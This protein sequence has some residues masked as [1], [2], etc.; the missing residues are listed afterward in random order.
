MLNY[1]QALEWVQGQVEAGQ[2]RLTAKTFAKVQGMVV[3]GLWSKAGRSILMIDSQTGASRQALIDMANE[4]SPLRLLLN[5]RWAHYLRNAFKDPEFSLKDGVIRP[6]WQTMIIQNLPVMENLL[7]EHKHKTLSELGLD[8]W[9]EEQFQ[10][11]IVILAHVKRKNYR[12]CYEHFRLWGGGYTDMDG[13]YLK[14]QIPFDYLL[15]NDKANTIQKQGARRVAETMLRI[16]KT[17]DQ[18]FDKTVTAAQ[19]RCI[20]RQAQKG[21]EGGTEKP[22]TKPRPEMSGPMAEYM[23]LHRHSIARAALIKHPKM[24]T[25]SPICA[26]TRIGP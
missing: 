20:D 24:A 14:R 9:S 2:F 4:G 3:D 15:C 12:P 1:N 21:I 25:R 17:E 7:G 11:L 22:D 5:P 19:A 16:L 23:N 10:K 13:K 18:R 6:K 8:P 26:Q